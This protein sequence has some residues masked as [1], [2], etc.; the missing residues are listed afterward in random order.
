MF[1]IEDILIIN[2]DYDNCTRRSLVIDAGVIRRTVVRIGLT[3]NNQLLANVFQ[4][5]CINFERIVLTLIATKLFKLAVRLRTLI[6][7][8]R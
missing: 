1:A 3:K 4:G 2:C 5:L 6:L 7:I 8:V